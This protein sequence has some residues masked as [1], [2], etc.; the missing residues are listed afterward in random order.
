MKHRKGNDLDSMEAFLS[1]CV[2]LLVAVA[3]KAG[4]KQAAAAATSRS[5][6]L[7][8]FVSEE[9]ERTKEGRKA[10]LNIH[11]RSKVV[12]D[13]QLR[14]SVWRFCCPVWT[15]EFLHLSAALSSLSRCTFLGCG[16]ADGTA[17]LLW[18]CSR[19]PK[20]LSHDSA[21]NS[22]PDG[23]ACVRGG[24]CSSTTLALMLALMLAPSASLSEL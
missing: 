9:K 21:I 19:H 5:V 16:F 4:V 18:A 24:S 1:C 23:W 3:A 22:T 15:G 11:Q 6:T 17:G 12:S 14:V 8:L 2:L 13:P 10:G 7:H 20:L